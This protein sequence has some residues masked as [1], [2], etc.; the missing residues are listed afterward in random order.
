MSAMRRIRSTRSQQHAA[1]RFYEREGYRKC[2]A[3]GPYAAM[4][5]NAIATSVF[6]EKR[7]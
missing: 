3:F 2:V 7:I 1:V 6:F 4:P 5:A